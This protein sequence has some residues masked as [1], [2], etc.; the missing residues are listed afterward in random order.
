M[1][2]CYQQNAAGDRRSDPA[3]QPG[4]KDRPVHNVIWAVIALPSRP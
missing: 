1:L 4:G 2:R 3:S